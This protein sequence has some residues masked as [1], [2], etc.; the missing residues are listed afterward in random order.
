MAAPDPF[1]QVSGRPG[2]RGIG[3]MLGEKF[4]ERAN[5]HAAKKGKFPKEK[6]VAIRK[7]TGRQRTDA[8]QG[9]EYEVVIEE[10]GGRD[11]M[12]DNNLSGALL[13]LWKREVDRKIDREIQREK[14]G[15]QIRGNT[16]Q[17]GKPKGGATYAHSNLE[18]REKTAQGGWKN[19]K[20]IDLE[21]TESNTS[22]EDR[23]AAAANRARSVSSSRGENSSAAPQGEGRTS[24]SEN[25]EPH[26]HIDLEAVESPLKGSGRERSRRALDEIVSSI[27]DGRYGESVS[28]NH[29]LQLRHRL[30]DTLCP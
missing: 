21:A 28:H 10:M 30:V 20:K 22:C 9:V 18:N 6:V 19:G 3:A 1:V 13:E 26:V 25:S 17:D 5:Q 27:E 4:R 7:L 24:T 23:R 14:E 12:G 29:L 2:K 15:P 16:T 11:W 8:Q